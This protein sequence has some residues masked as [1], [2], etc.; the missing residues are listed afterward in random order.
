MLEGI[1]TL[2]A[3]TGDVSLKY[4]PDNVIGEL[5]GMLQALDARVTALEEAE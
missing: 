2:S 1:N 5:K 3:N 4:Q